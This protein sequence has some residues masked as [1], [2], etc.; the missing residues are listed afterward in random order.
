MEV[1]EVLIVVVHAKCSFLCKYSNLQSKQI[2]THNTNV[3]GKCGVDI[4][5][6][7]MERRGANGKEIGF[8]CI[9]ININNATSKI[10]NYSKLLTLPICV[11][12]NTILNDEVMQP[13][14]LH[15]FA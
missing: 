14:Q 7:L 2:N 12:L 4:S 6:M 3:I 13:V 15:Q 5:I 1:K 8:L 9:K 11:S 10:W